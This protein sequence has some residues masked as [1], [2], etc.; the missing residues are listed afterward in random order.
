M[1]WITVYLT[2]EL[3]A[4]SPFYFLSSKSST[5]L[6]S[7]A[8]KGP[9]VTHHD[10]NIEEG[11]KKK[12]SVEYRVGRRGSLQSDFCV[13]LLPPLQFICFSGVSIPWQNVCI[14]N[15][16]SFWFVYTKGFCDITSY[17]AQA[18]IFW[19]K[20][21][22]VNNIIIVILKTCLKLCFWRF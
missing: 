3:R 17:K 21:F 14:T 13:K 19:H 4:S 10:K 6:T 22:S 20:Q 5:L 7:L 16:V 1:F 8:E 12:N 18:I 11:K 9:N 2:K 15:L